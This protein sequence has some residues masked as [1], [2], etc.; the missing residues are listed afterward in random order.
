MAFGEIDVVLVEDGSP[1]E[2]CSYG[3]CQQLFQTRKIMLLHT[4]QFLASGAMAVLRVQWLLPA[5]L[6]L[7]LPTMAAC[8]ISHLEIRIVVMDLVWCTV[9]PVI[10]LPMHLA[11]ITI[12]TIFT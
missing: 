1:L 5:Q 7:D 12:I 2:G 8:L 11:L 6:I 9:F 10:L 3:T 4:M